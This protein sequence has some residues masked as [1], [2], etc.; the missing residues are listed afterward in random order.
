M[1]AAGRSPGWL[2]EPA[3][4]VRGPISFAR[5]APFALVSALQG[6]WT[7]SKSRRRRHYVRCMC[8]GPNTGR[9]IAAGTPA[10]IG[11]ASDHS[12]PGRRLTDSVAICDVRLVGALDP[13]S[14]ISYTPLKVSSTA[15][16]A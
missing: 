2:V 13:C 8:D 4:T 5:S 9:R 7:R 11:K 14:T 16:W 1:T 12:V 6:E 3:D 10:S 15:S